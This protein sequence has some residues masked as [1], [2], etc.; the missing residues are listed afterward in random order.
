MYL[1]DTHILLWSLDSVENLS[2]K[3]KEVLQFEKVFVST[4]SLWEIAI[5]KSLGKLDIPFTP[6]ELAEICRQR[7]IEILP[8]KPKHLD[9][10]LELPIIH[11]DPFDRLLICQAQTENLTM[12]TRDTI[13]PKYPVK[14]L[15]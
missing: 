7:D 14:I 4:V 6:S 1:I 3:A 13:I 2:P 11:N 8:I 12:V 9:W 5:K 15:W 10:L